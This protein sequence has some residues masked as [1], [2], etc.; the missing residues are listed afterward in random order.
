MSS[1]DLDR[2]P[3]ESEL[4][5]IN[6]LGT[7]KYEGLIDMT[8]QELADVFNKNLRQDGA[9]WNESTYRKKFASMRHISE[10]FGTNYSSA[11]ADE[12]RELR[13]ELEKEKVKL[14]DERTA[15][16]KLIRDE[17]RK[18][19]FKEQFIHAIEEAA[20][21][22]ALEYHDHVST[23][24]VS[25]NDLLIPLTD[26]HAGVSINNFWNSYSEDIMI[27]RLNHYLDRIFEI[28]KRHNSQ[29]AYVVISEAINGFIHPLNRIQSNQDIIDQ[30]LMIIGYISDFIQALS[31]K[32]QHVYIY[33]APGNHSRLNAK[34]DENLEHENLDNLIIPF[35]KQKFQNYKNVHAYVNDIEQ[36]MAVFSIRNINVCAVHG[37]KDCFDNVA[38]SIN[39]LLKTRIDLILIGHLH[40]NAMKTTGDVKVIRSGCLSGSD[41]YAINHRLRN[42]PEQ[43]V[44]VISD[45][46]GLDCVYDIKF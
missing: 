32:F 12:L 15:Y 23:V 25:D 44:C 28:Q 37:D 18:E 24:T 17:A 35:L 21:R 10:E 22:Y 39:K 40:T 8:W 36:S 6:R 27:E 31:E 34:K 20:G 5:Y 30:F 7:A 41:E 4:T 16:N 14:R 29:D 38:D 13:R 42:R 1:V 2:K 43:A 45:Q 46:E 9:W 26:I 11:D 3:G 19:S 33:V